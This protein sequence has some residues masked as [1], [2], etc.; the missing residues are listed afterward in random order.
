MSSSE[1]EAQSKPKQKGRV[2]YKI[3]H[4]LKPPR[5]TT[6]TAQSLYDQIVDG[7]INL[8]PEYQRDVVWST[9]K[10]IGLIDSIF[11]NFY[12][13][14]LIFAVST[15]EDGTEARTCIDG[16]QRLTSIQKFMDGLI[17]HRDPD[18]AR[19]KYY[20]TNPAKN[21][22]QLPPKYKNLFGTKQI[23]CIEYFDL[24]ENDER[25]IFRRVQLGMAL[26]DAEKM[27]ALARNMKTELVQDLTNNYTE[28]LA[29][30]GFRTARD[31]VY[32]WIATACFHIRRGSDAKTSTTP[33]QLNKWL[34]EEGGRNA[35]TEVMAEGIRE[36]ME[37][38]MDI[39]EMP[40]SLEVSSG[41]R[42]LAPVDF[43][44]GMYLVYVLR[45]HFSA[46]GLFRAIR[47]AR[48]RVRNDADNV[49]YN[50]NICRTYYEFIEHLED[51]DE[52]ALGS[53]DEMDVDEQPQPKKRKVT[54]RKRKEPSP[55][56]SPSPEPAPRT[57]RVSSAKAKKATTTTRK[58]PVV[59]TRNSPPIARAQANGF[60]GLTSAS[61]GGRA[62]NR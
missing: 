54:K 49:M 26:N 55:S 37:K 50:S 42:T 41:P 62:S 60:S 15:H 34:A 20:F 51:N 56:T 53:D 44:M 61:T 24:D 59:K 3:K 40:G 32:R 2:D 35:M 31:T 10:Q 7:S 36:S 13:P 12:I 58:S 29:D 6:Y 38:F 33:N 28:R 18:N 46:D 1:D 22:F 27:K 8:G 43:V 5:S 9:E 17:Y 30:L 57:S 14:P 19:D 47:Q 16:K 39:I 25:E 23:V 21:S 52:G 4:A 11:R 45:D 48:Q